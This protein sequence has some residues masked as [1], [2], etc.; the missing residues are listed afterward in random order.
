[1]APVLPLAAEDE[2]LL[3]TLLLPTAVTQLCLALPSWG[4]AEKTRLLQAYDQHLN[5]ILGEVEETI[6][7]IEIDDETYEEIVKVCSRDP[8]P[9]P[10]TLFSCPARRGWQA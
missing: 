4:R 6:T 2:L 5:M 3:Q 8:V 9:H 7:T 10:I 1:M